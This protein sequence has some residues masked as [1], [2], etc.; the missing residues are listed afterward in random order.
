MP[1]L[2]VFKTDLLTW[3][4]NFVTREINSLVTEFGQ[5]V[6]SFFI[7]KIDSLFPIAAY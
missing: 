2:I 3:I 1:L 6:I 7:S 4:A 5:E